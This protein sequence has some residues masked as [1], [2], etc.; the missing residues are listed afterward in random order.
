MPAQPDPCA[1]AKLP[2]I[3]AEEY[4]SLGLPIAPPLAGSEN[5]QLSTLYSQ[6]HA[7]PDGLTALCISGGGIR[8]ATFAWGAITALAERNLLPGFH[9]LSTV[10]GG[11]YIGS[12]LSAWIHRA[13]G[14]IAQ[15]I[16]RLSGTADGP[17]PE[18]SEADPIQ[19]L[20]EYNNY[21]TPRFG[22]GSPD[23][24]TMIA[25]ILRNLVLNWTVMLPLLLL[26]V[27]AP[28]VLVSL[29]QLNPPFSPDPVHNFGYVQV[30][31]LAIAGIAFSWATYFTVSY[32]PSLGRAPNTSR[33]FIRNCLLP[34][35]LCSVTSLLAFWWVWDDLDR[36]PTALELTGSGL[37]LSAVSMIGLMLATPFKALRG[38]R[39]TSVF[40]L[41]LAILIW[42]MSS[43]A[44]AYALTHWLFNSVIPSNEI[45]DVTSD[46]CFYAAFGPPLL[47]CGLLL[48]V[49]VLVGCTS[50]TLHEADREW[51]GRSAAYALAFSV[52]WVAIC[53]LVLVLP[54]YLLQ[55]D[56]MAHAILASAG[57]ISGLV[58]ALAGNSGKTAATEAS[59]EQT[60][61]SDKAVALLYKLALPV[62]LLCLFLGLTLL[63]NL[64]LTST[65]LAKG[66]WYQHHLIVVELPATTALALTALMLLLSWSM[67][68]FVNVNK[69]SLHA[70]YE[71]R[72]SRAYLGAS[73]CEEKPHPFTGFCNNDD[74]PISELRGQRPLHVVNMALN[75]VS[76]KRLAWQQRKATSFTV[77]PY[78][79]GN[80][81][82]GY[83]DSALYGGG[84]TLGNAMTISGAAASPNMGYN[85]SP[86]VSFTMMLFNARLGSWLGNPGE[87]GKD[88]WKDEG[89]RSAVSSIVREA[90][91]KTD[92]A[93]PYVYL[94]D[95]GHFENL[96]LYEMIL[97]RCRTIVVLD[98]GCDPNYR[99]EDLGNA[100]RKIRIDLN[101]R[102]EFDP[103]QLD[104]LQKKERSF[105]VA[106]ILYA[107][108]DPNAPEG[109]LLYI[110]PMLHG[111]EPPDVLSYRAAHPTFPHETT[112]DQ[113]FT[114]AQ[115]E[116]YRKL[117]SFIV[118]DLCATFDG[119]G[120]IAG[121]VRHAE[122]T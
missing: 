114:E 19:H 30:A 2:D 5:Y 1:P 64:L 86:L 17:T 38:I 46:A 16:R 118:E 75:L 76:S 41:G 69:F 21:L 63:T 51:L 18:T 70:M 85:S 22:L 79:A 24:W 31:L 52:G 9:Y 45:S 91:G 28:R 39:S 57:G 33:Q 73:K 100:L 26:V 53:A 107:D 67:G 112:A 94:S 115:T 102:I 80:L 98:A 82:L 97:R 119:A 87:A 34:M 14:G 83:R 11:G 36:V 7:S 60:S 109:R 8:S 62:F 37:L 81:S 106:R 3:L 4:A 20:R 103:R 29:L 40:D 32:L 117:G 27:L 49:V 10:S 54:H 89:P 35:V 61:S 74:L 71:N 104:P 50:R 84:I 96:A 56:S 122:S 101:I 44:A 108:A 88:T 43:G 59:P 25:I 65:G 66:A 113:W 58:T 110:K 15:V 6:I 42:G 68:R 99:Y 116:S 111:S 105:A 48:G 92:D 72:L 23:T 12:W 120:G 121:L 93:G 78:R 47:I 95:G 77:S 90:L 13:P 55:L